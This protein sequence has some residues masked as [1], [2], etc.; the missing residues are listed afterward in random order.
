MSDC[1]HGHAAEKRANHS[2][3]SKLISPQEMES[4]ISQA[5]PFYSEA[6]ILTFA[7]RIRIHPGIV[8]GQLQHRGLIPWSAYS[9]LKSKIREIL[10]ATALTDGFGHHLAR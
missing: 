8:V 6:A 4:F 1:S 3:A 10:T 9:K 5:K 2:A 7:K